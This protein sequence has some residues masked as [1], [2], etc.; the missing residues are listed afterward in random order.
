MN[1][2]IGF[3]ETTGYTPAMIAL[4]VMCKTAHV[5]ALPSEVNDFLGFVVKVSGEIDAVQSAIEAGKQ[6]ATELGGE[7]VVKILANPENQIRPVINGPEEYNGLLEQN[8]VHHPVEDEVNQE[9][10]EMTNDNS[11]A[12]GFIETQGF[13]AIFNAIDQACK[14]ANVEVVGK[15]KLGGG[16]VTVIIKGDVAA[17]KAAVEA[18][19]AEVEQLGTLIAAYVIPRPSTSVLSLLP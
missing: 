3:L 8:V 1:A 11:Y 10:E 14:A 17:V 7:P 5:E 15:E 4:D 6:I 12:L 13:T 18:G 2:A 9:D 19:E 16:Y